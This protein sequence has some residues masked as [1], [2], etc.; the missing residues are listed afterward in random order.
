MITEKISM[1]TV[2]LVNHILLDAL[3][4]NASD[5]HFDPCAAHCRLRMRIDGI[6]TTHS[7]LPHPVYTA[8]LARIKTLSNLDIAQQKLPQDGRLAFYHEQHQAQFRVHTC[9]SIHGE[10]MVLRL[11]QQA[12]RCFP[13]NELGLL[14]CQVN[15]LSNIL[16]QT[17]GLIVV[18]GPT[19]CGK[20]MTLY[21]MIHHLMQSC[22]QI[23]TLE[24]P[25]EMVIDGVSQLQVH[26]KQ[27][28]DFATLLRACLRQ[29]PDVLMI[30]EIRDEETAQIAIRAALTGH[31]V[32]TSLH[33]PSA[34]ASLTRL[35]NM[36][37]APYDLDECLRAVIAQRLIRLKYGE[38]FAGRSGIF[39]I[40]QPGLQ[41]LSL[42]AV[43]NLKVQAGLSTQAEIQRVI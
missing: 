10:K 32:L 31:L 41:H 33:T 5:I 9:A 8:L 19:G 35:R 27:Q 12:K 18:C 38:N 6:I 21:A 29:D 23:I 39:E 20:T 36:G 25:V 28:L 16:K 4:L 1:H 14:T 37:I 17:H 24:D 40:F 43:A 26:R 13:L 7:E 34:Q 30:G 11:I 3:K 42:E 22:L 2:E 15:T